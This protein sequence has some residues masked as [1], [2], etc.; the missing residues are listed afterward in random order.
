[1]TI[2][3]SILQ[4]DAETARQQTQ[5]ILEVGGPLQWDVVDGQFAD[6]HT[7]EPQDLDEALF[8]DRSVD[9]HLMV[10]DPS[11][12]LG[13]YAGLS[14]VRGVIAQ[15][16]RLPDPEDFLTAAHDHGFVAGFSFDVHTPLEE[17]PREVL[18]RA[19]LLQIMG[20]QA[21]HQGQPFQS[22]VLKK[23]ND[24]REMAV[25]DSQMELLV[26]G[27][28]KLEMLADLFA[29]GATGVVVGSAIWGSDNPRKSLEDFR[30]AASELKS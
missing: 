19:D 8:A 15:V 11:Q 25:L 21:G 5:L 29:A 7:L 27:G 30:L 28:V 2:Y 23:L 14:Y 17:F 1:M 16:E 12:W 13:A 18:Q 24:L 10:V 9:V 3:P 22:K 4:S 26:D 20:V 6:N